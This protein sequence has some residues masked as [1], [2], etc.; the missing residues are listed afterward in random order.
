MGLDGPYLEFQF[1]AYFMKPLHP[2]DMNTVN[3]IKYL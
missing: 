3:V 1:P 2:V